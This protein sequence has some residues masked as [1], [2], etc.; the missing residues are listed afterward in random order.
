M[1]KFAFPL[2]RVMDWRGTQVRIE[3]MKLEVLYAEL[4]GIDGQI[5]AVVTARDQSA[6]ALIT[7][8][9]VTGA[10]LAA[11]DAFARFSV[12]EH[13]R[14]SYARVDCSRRTDA[15]MQ[16]VTA[17]RRDVRLL[18]RLKGQ[19]LLKWNAE[20]SKEIDAQAEESHI[21]KWCSRR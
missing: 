12:G 5:A 14:L 3:E 1:K 2:D 19:Q 7:A 13:A 6:Q 4:R 9:S 11:I 15:Q 18:E 16:V 20:F 17:K 21:A 10:E 8:A